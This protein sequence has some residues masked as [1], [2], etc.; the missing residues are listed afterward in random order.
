[1]VKIYGPNPQKMVLQNLGPPHVGPPKKFFLTYFSTLN[2]DFWSKK[3]KV[4]RT[5]FLGPKIFD[6]FW[7]FKCRFRQKYFNAC[8]YVRLVSFTPKCFVLLNLFMIYYTWHNMTPGGGHVRK[9]GSRDHWVTWPDHVIHFT[10]S[11]AFNKWP[12]GP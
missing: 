7:W 12:G 10:I 6:S 3:N 11:V 2:T 4:P 8:I 9:G 1:M 5:K